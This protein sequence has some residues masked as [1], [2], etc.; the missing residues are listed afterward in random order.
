MNK[1]RR[2]VLLAPGI[3]LFLSCAGAARED[4]PPSIEPASTGRVEAKAPKSLDATTAPSSPAAQIIEGR[5]LFV[6]D[7]ASCEAWEIDLPNIL[8][9]SRGRVRHAASAGQPSVVADFERQGGELMLEAPC[10]GDKKGFCLPCEL[11]AKPAPESPLRAFARQDECEERRAGASA[12]IRGC[13]AAL[14]AS[15]RKQVARVLDGSLRDEFIARL[16][17]ARIVS[18]G[19]GADCIPLHVRKAGKRLFLDWVASEYPEE[20]TRSANGIVSIDEVVEP[21]PRYRSRGPG[22][23]AIGCC[24]GNAYHVVA[25]GKDAATLRTAPRSGGEPPRVVEF[26]M[27][28]CPR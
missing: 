12:E 23:I 17:A 24:G 28:D 25:L 1:T 3:A 21:N 15:S 16:S 11:L 19:S 14:A 8:E 20:V 26:R 13:V 22:E 9:D 6:S 18:R 2:L 4:S 10:F 7:G 5:K 27:S